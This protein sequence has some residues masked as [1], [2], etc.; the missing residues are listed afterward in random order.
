MTEE[1]LKKEIENKKDEQGRNYQLTS[2]AEGMM[3]HEDFSASI[4]ERLKTPETIDLVRL[5][6]KDLGFTENPT[7]DELY[8]RAGELGLELCPPEVG[9][10]LRLKYEDVF[11]REQP[12]YEYLRIAKKQIADSDGDLNVFNV[13]RDDGGF[14]LDNNWTNHSNRWNLDNEFVF[15]LRKRFLFPRSQITVFLFRALSYFFFPSPQHSAD[16]IE[17]GARQ[18][19]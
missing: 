14:W 13:N 12:M 10:Y 19:H 5:R 15:R 4:Q 9:P 8:K 17:F 6:V 11:Q 18:S 16:F 3:K 2:Y 1:E 7:T